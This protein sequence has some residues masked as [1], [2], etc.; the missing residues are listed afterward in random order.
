MLQIAALVH[1]WCNHRPAR[2]DVVIPG[3]ASAKVTEGPAVTEWCLVLPGACDAPPLPAAPRGP[4]C[5]PGSSPGPP[6]APHVA[7]GPAAARRAGADRFRC[8]TAA[9]SNIG[10]HGTD[11]P[12]GDD[13]RGGTDTGGGAGNGP[14]RPPSTMTTI[15]F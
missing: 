1:C 2:R 7:P 9:I 8:H 12:G 10:R 13:G 3:H 15:D 5:P 6:A 14:S 4:W 11:A